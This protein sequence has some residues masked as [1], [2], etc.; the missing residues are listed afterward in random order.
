[1]PPE[2]ALLTHLGPCVGL[3]TT[4]GVG[5]ERNDGF[6]DRAGGKLPFVRHGSG[7]SI[8]P[9]LARGDPAGMRQ[10]RI[11][12]NRLTAE[13]RSQVHWL[14]SA[15]AAH[16]RA[17]DKVVSAWYRSVLFGVSISQPSKKFTVD[18]ITRNFVDLYKFLV[19]GCG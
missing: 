2:P 3:V 17:N 15:R 14:G 11:L 6:R 13:T 18:F 7:G 16:H 8:P 10:E 19:A 9:R 5:R 4:S 1:M 12:N